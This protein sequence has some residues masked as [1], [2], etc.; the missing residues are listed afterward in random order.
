[1]KEIKIEIKNSWTGKILFEYEKEDNTLKNT[2]IEAIKQDIDLR[3][4]DLSRADLRGAD[5]NGVDIRGADL[6]GAN[7][8]GVDIRGADL[9]GAN[10]NGV[11]IRGADLS[12]ADLRGVNLRGADLRGANLNGV[13]I[14]GADLRRANLNGV[15]IRGAD[16]RGANLNGVDIRGA[17]LRRVNFSRANLNGVDLLNADLR[18]AN[19]NGVDI[20]GADL[21]R[22]DLRDANIKQIEHQFQIIPMEGSFIAWKK[23]AH[24]CLAKIEIPTKSPRTFSLIG[25]KCRAKY[26][27]TL[28]ITDPQGDKIKECPGKRDRSIIY[29]VGMLTHSD[30]WDNNKLIECTHG[31]H[32]FISKQ[33]ALDWQL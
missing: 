7:L 25:R 24:G 3:G 29:K 19:L 8:N 4:V 33:E 26:V 28:E 31:I 9:R 13:D 5:L 1:M 10:L 15:D 17:D 32:F 11:D 2:L 16:L 30:K 22:A 18:R 27:K 6:R 14:R 23:L 12:R 20:R 21:S